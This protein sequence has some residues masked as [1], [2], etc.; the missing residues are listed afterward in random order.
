MFDGT[1]GVGYLLANN[2]VETLSYTALGQWFSTTGATIPTVQQ[3]FST[4]VVYGQN[5][6]LYAN[7]IIP[8][9]AGPI[10][11]NSSF[12]FQTTSQTNFP[13][14]AFP[15]SATTQFVGVLN[16]NNTTSGLITINSARVGGQILVNGTSGGGD[17]TAGN[18]LIWPMSITAPITLPF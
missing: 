18:T 3:T 7:Y 17:F 14:T 11:A 12:V 9:F 8:G 2:A 4:T 15:S 1:V 10:S 16:N 13:V 6:M 5:G